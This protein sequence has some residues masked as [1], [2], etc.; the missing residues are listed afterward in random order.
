ME[1]LTDNT[2]RIHAGL[3]VHTGAAVRKVAAVHSSSNLL[4]LKFVGVDNRDDADSLRGKYLEVETTEVEPL[5]EGSYYHWQLLG[6]EVFDIAG[7]R[8]GTISD[9]IDNPA[10][11]VYVVSGDGGQVLIPAIVEVVRNVDLDAGR[12]VVDLPEEEVV[13]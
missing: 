4:I 7:T 13:G 2:G 11:D 1:P 12:M 6:L 5:P 3:S 10:N 8:L 9:I